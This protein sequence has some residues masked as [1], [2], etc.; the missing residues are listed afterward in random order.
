MR[1]R[2]GQL[3]AENAAPPELPQTAPETMFA[4]HV[5]R[6]RTEGDVFD[7]R[8]TL[9]RA[10]RVGR[11]AIAGAAAG[12][13]VTMNYALES[14]PG[15]IAAGALFTLGAYGQ[16]WHRSRRDKQQAKVRYN[17][18]SQ[19]ENDAAY[20]LYAVG[21]KKPD[22]THEVAM[23]WHGPLRNE[24][25]ATGGEE[26]T[27]IAGL[28]KQN[29]IERLILD[30]SLAVACGDGTVQGFTTAFTMRQW[31]ADTK[32]I[33][34]K[35]AS[36]RQMIVEAN[37]D[38]WLA[39][40]SKGNLHLRT[41]RVTA[42]QIPTYHNTAVHHALRQASGRSYRRS[43]AIGDDASQTVTRVTV[44]ER[45]RPNALRYGDVQLQVGL[46]EKSR[47][48]SRRT[49]PAIRHAGAIALAGV[50]GIV[51]ASGAI[52][53]G[54]ARYDRIAQTEAAHIA[55][56][57]G[58]DPVVADVDPQAVRERMYGI[59]SGNRIWNYG[60]EARDALARWI[61]V[62][63]TGDNRQGLSPLTGG[64]GNLYGSSVDSHWKLTPHNMPDGQ[65]TGNWSIA[66]SARV[67]SATEA[68]KEP[69][70]VWQAQELF[71]HADTV[72]VMSAR[73]G[74]DAQE[75]QWI[76]VEAAGA[77]ETIVRGALV[78]VPVPVRDG[79]QITAAALAGK[80]LEWVEMPN[81][82]AA[83]RV[84]HGNLHMIDQLEYWV[85]LAGSADEPVRFTG[86]RAQD[87]LSVPTGGDRFVYDKA[88]IREA[89]E[90]EVPGFTHMTTAERTAYLHNKLGY[91]R[92][93]IA[94]NTLKATDDW[95][96]FT[97]YPL[98]ARRA[99]CGFAGTTLIMANAVSGGENL[100]AVISYQ[101]KN[102]G[103]GLL[104]DSVEAHLRAVN[105]QG[106]I[107]D[108]TP[109]R[110]LTAQS[111]NS[112]EPL[113]PAP[114]TPWFAIAGVGIAAVGVYRS[115]HRL[116]R[117]VYRRAA[118]WEARTEADRAAAEAELRSLHPIDLRQAQA[119][120]A[121]AGW[122]KP[123]AVLPRDSVVRQGWNGSVS[124]EQALQSLLT[125]SVHTDQARRAVLR[126]KAVTPDIKRVLS[127]ARRAARKR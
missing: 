104:L 111:M 65:L 106:V 48:I 15:M 108:P 23:H 4:D 66:T 12:L 71:E 68:G 78:Y 125:P 84:P 2:S 9:R 44:P 67:V 60:R 57:N 73:P 8:S 19:R 123:G 89:L 102:D 86:P 49:L 127:V 103:K 20:E 24:Q 27:R 10:Y 63:G 14:A 115:R 105:E 119:A 117:S 72:T 122:G 96:E 69:S 41:V 59:S 43:L 52:M 53:Y 124:A 62:E 28:A 46:G 121:F 85:T 99:N 21:K 88:A 75:Q 45:L 1:S 13:P 126:Q 7:A 47:D 110:G 82:T 83:V 112:V 55:I 120:V 34:T 37:P 94:K 38:D 98:A 54:D 77:P 18:Q 17:V 58:A 92:A 109:E 36:E 90:Q 39:Y 31:L 113:E 51:V 107:Y 114:L 42:R 76:K 61:S 3:L 100:N 29:G 116:R 95:A 33:G 22:G 50:A 80:P 25:N 97:T 118:A 6:V 5:A 11:A 70:V 87:D 35:G 56:E 32:G 79:M 40:A 91:K 64:V 101:N 93:P 16:G 74:P 30:G 26:L 81:G